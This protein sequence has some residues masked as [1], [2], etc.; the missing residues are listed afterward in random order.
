V[1]GAGHLVHMPAHI[2]I[3]TGDY[4]ASAKSNADA[5]RVDEKYVQ[6]TGAKGM[7]PLM[8]YGHNL[9]FESAALM[10]AGH[11]E[12]ARAAAQKT[13]ALVTPIA[14][15]VVMVQPFALQE[16]LVFVR[17]GKWDEALAL[18]PPPSGRPV[19]EAL[20][21]FIRGAALAAKRDLAGARKEAEALAVAQK[22]IP[23]DAAASSANMA[24]AVVE[25]ARHDLK[26]RIADA[27]RDPKLAVAAWRAAVAAE[28]M[29]GYAEPPD[30]LLPTR[31]GLGAALLRAGEPVEAETVFREDLAVFHN[32][33]RSLFGLW[34]SLDRQGRNA[35]AAAAQSQFEHA[36]RGADT[37]LD[38]VAMK[39]AAR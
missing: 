39:T 25:V 29:L 31:E 37:K 2:Y 8:Y 33:P 36:W 21:H 12:G 26:A 19:Q 22:L 9:Q 34:R 14:G 10:F 23:A 20:F 11:Y 38:D 1:P 3:R 17:F 13:V 35:D 30:W 4:L 6:A 28:E 27:G 16:G 18:A 15:E 32:N 24:S 5:A 7:Y